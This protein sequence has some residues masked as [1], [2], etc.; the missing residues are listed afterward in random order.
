M[1]K[2]DSYGSGREIIGVMRKGEY[3]EVSMNPVKGETGKYRLG[4]WVR[5]DLAGV[6]H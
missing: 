5:D 1:D 6:E 4:I 3:V 2:I